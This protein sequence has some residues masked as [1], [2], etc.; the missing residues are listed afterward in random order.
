M[1]IVGIWYNFTTS[2]QPTAPQKI[3]AFLHRQSHLLLLYNRYLV[4]KY[5]LGGFPKGGFG[6]MMRAMAQAHGGDKSPGCL[7]SDRST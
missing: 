5:G 6:L 3:K 4:F 7:A 1:M 2:S